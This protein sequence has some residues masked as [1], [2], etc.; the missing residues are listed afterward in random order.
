MLQ[1]CCLVLFIEITLKAT[2]I[3]N[4]SYAVC[5]FVALFQSLNVVLHVNALNV[6]TSV[7]WIFD[8]L[9]ILF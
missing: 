4:D 2:E 8:V 6:L 1:V 7:A 5:K 3:Q 9:F